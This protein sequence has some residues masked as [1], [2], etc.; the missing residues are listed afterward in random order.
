MVV[1]NLQCE[2]TTESYIQIRGVE[3]ALIYN[4]QRYL[5]VKLT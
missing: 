1:N 3:G 2:D 5:V 4:R